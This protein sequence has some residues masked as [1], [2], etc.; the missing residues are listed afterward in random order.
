[1]VLSDLVRGH[2]ERAIDISLQSI[3]Q[4]LKNIRTM[5]E[6]LHLKEEEDYVFGLAMGYV[7]G[8]FEAFYRLVYLKAPS[9]EDSSEVIR[10]ILRRSRDI[11]DAIFSVG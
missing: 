10:I 2:V 8:T 6:E 4:T 1:M 11:R 5:K 3:P 9:A 7:I